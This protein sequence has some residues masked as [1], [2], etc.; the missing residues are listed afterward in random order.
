MGVSGKNASDG[1][2]EALGRSFV[3]ARLLHLVETEIIPGLMRRHLDLNLR[4]IGSP[5]DP[6][7][8]NLADP[9]AFARLVIRGD[10][11][12][13]GW[14]LKG[15]IEDGMGPG[16]IC[17]DLLAPTAQSL[18]ALWEQDGCSLDELTRGLA[19]IRA[20]VEDLSSSAGRARPDRA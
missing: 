9:Q 18:R 15:L 3:H 8:D 13:I 14:R 19:C 12:E 17:L 11:A 10:L 7:I 2:D 16:Q 6:I 5:H 1:E 20:V 4:L